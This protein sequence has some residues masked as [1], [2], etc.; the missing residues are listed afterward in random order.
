MKVRVPI[1]GTVGKSVTFDPNAGARAEAAVAALA[2]QL[3]AGLGGSTRHSAL[4]GLQIGDDH[5]QYTGNQFPETVTGQWNFQTIPFIQ[6]NTLAEYIEDV[7]GGSFFDFL[8]DTSSVVWTFFDTANELEANVPPEFVQDTIGA[9]LTDT[10]SIDLVYSDGANTITAN[11][12]DEY[13]QDLVGAMLADS[14][15]IDFT[16]ND[17]AGTFTAATINANP[18]GLIGMTAVNGTATT[19]L[20]SDGRHA[21]DP[22]IAPTWTALHTYSNSNDAIRITG[23]SA[24]LGFQNTSATTDKGR[25]R[26]FAD[27]TT[28]TLS[29]LNDAANI[30]RN[31]LDVGRGAGAAIAYISLGNAIDN[32]TFSFLGT[33]L[34]TFG[35]T[36]SGVAGNWSGA[37]TFIAALGVPSFANNGLVL[38]AGSSGGKLKFVSAGAATDAKT[39]ELA[40]SGTLFLIRAVDDVDGSVGNIL[41]ATRSGIAV[42]SIVLGNAA[43]LTP[44]RLAADNQELQLGASQDLRLFHDGTDS[45]VRNDTGILKLASGA[46]SIFE[47]TAARG[48]FNVPFRSKAYTVAT[49]PAGV[50]GDRAHVTDALAPVFLGII[51]GGGAVITPV[52]HNGTNWVA[53]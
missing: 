28:F 22:A 23:N 25:Y 1:S 45:W 31:I 42:T 3:S 4:Q 16:Y 15:S 7:V 44:V 8:Q 2:A 36:I 39:V 32:N 37:H 47:V 17:G 49:L 13:V 6:G 27:P 29:S 26:M 24:L 9:I 52:F 41:N 35:G 48:T 38:G 40:S 34:A 33:G 18:S 11:I 43:D 53:E 46:T 30:A 14:T 19:P 50:Q 5:P 20:R 21:I 12:I 10:A 51:A